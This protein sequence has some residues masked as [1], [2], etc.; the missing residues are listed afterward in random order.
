MG[1]LG[2]GLAQAGVEHGDLGI[3]GALVGQQRLGGMAIGASR[4]SVDF[5]SGHHAFSNGDKGFVLY[6]GKSAPMTT[7]AKVTTSTA[8]IPALCRLLVTALTVAPVV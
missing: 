7:R 2:H 5:Y 1:A 6:M 4:G 3:V 8:S